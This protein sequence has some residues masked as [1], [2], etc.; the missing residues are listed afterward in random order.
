[1][2][3]NIHWHNGRLIAAGMVHDE[4]AC[5]G[6]RRIVDGVADTMQCHRGTVVAVLDPAQHSF[7]ILVRDGPNPAFNGV[8]SAAIIGKRIWLGS[9]QADRLAVSSTGAFTPPLKD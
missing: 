7:E 5:G 8:S 3:D 4:P 9:Y 2:P 6:V 1:M